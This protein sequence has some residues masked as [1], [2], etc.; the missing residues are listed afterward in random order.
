MK[1]NIISLSI[2][3]LLIT[4]CTNGG[5]VFKDDI[6]APASYTDW[7][8]AI[9]VDADMQTMY[10]ATPRKIEKP[11]DMYMAF[12]L[13]LKYN[14]TRRLVSYQQSMIEVGKNPQNRLPEIFSSAGYVNTDN[15]D[16]MDSELKLAW[17]ILDVS[18]VY[19]QSKD[20]WYKTSVAYEQS[21]KVIH[22]LMQET[23]V[24]YW[25]ALSAQR[26]LPL[27]DEMIEYMTL[28]VDELNAKA[29]DSA[30]S[31]MSLNVA[32]LERKREFIQATK[33][34]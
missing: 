1:K 28:D 13:A 26:L 24:L 5:V 2:C 34:L 31:G 22:N 32:E 8:R 3:A 11:I 20:D 7:D 12:A 18:T 30:K 10:S 23:R 15:Q 14:Y 9:R 6:P 19:Y 17:N 4:A 29:V 21:R 16:V 25:K 33:E 27:I